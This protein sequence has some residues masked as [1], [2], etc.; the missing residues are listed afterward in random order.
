MLRKHLLLIRSSSFVHRLVSFN[1]GDH[2]WIVNVSLS[3]LRNFVEK[4]FKHDAHRADQ[5]VERHQ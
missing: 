1:S 2:S 3:H 4:Y 5:C